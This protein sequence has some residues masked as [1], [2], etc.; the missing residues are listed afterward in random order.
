MPNLTALDLEGT[1]F[2][3]KMAEKISRSTT[4]GSL[5]VGGTRLTRAGLAHLVTM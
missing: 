4:I 1:R 3:D 2:D 5:D